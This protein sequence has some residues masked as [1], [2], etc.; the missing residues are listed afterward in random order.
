MIPSSWSVAH[1]R[2]PCS[3]AA[4]APRLCMAFVLTFAQQGCASLASERALFLE[5]WHPG[6]VVRVDV[7]AA[8]GAPFRTDCRG[9]MAP[10]DAMQSHF[11]LVRYSV[12]PS[13]YAER[14]ALVADAGALR[15]GDRV[16]VNTKECK[17]PMMAP[18]V[19]PSPGIL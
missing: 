3:A 14:I 19:P 11:A 15:V 4:F 5:G 10:Q 12:S 6:R 9:E 1:A 7:G 13:R 8:I 2:V 18:A 17:A 16:Y